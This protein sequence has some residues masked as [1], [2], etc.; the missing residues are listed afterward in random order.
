M[1]DSMPGN[2]EISVDRDVKV[3]M[4]DGVILRAD[5]YRPQSDRPVPVL[6][7]RTPYGKGGAQSPAYL[8]PTWYARHGYLVVTQ[9]V[10]GR[11]VSGGDWYPFEHEA[12]DGYD[13]IEWAAGLDG[14]TGRVGMYGFSYPGACQL[15]AAAEQPPHL[16]CII[17]AMTASEYWEGWTY[18]GGALQQAFVQSWVVNELGS[19]TARRR[20]LTTLWQRLRDATRDIA[21][22]YDRLPLRDME[23]AHAE[24]LAPYYVDWIDHPTR[25]KY[26]DRWSP[27]LRHGRI[28]VPALHLGG[29]YDIFLEG[30]IR[31]FQGIRAKAPREVADTQRLV[32]G[33][34]YHM[35]WAAHVAGWHFGA[36]ASNRM[37]D[38]QLRWF[39]HWLKGD[40]NSIPEEPPVRRFVMGANRWEDEV[41]WP[42]PAARGIDL[43]LSS[44]GG[45]N[46]LNGEGR[47]QA[48]PDDEAAPDVFAY[49]PTSAVPSLG[50]RSCCS[51]AMTPMGPANQLP[52][53]ILNSVLVYT[54]PVLQA[55]VELA[56]P[57]TV[58]LHAS[59]TARDTDWT[60]KLVDVHSE[61]LAVNVA[62]GILRARYRLSAS[63]PEPIE[64][65]R[66]EEYVIDVGATSI[67]LRAGHRIRLEVSS[68]NFPAYDRN[69]NTGGPIGREDLA[70][71]RI[72]T[73][74]VYHDRE[75]PSRIALSVIGDLRFHE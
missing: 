25:D 39:D 46:S 73:Q 70:A 64:P 54:S 24:E 44:G 45:A 71:A 52:V 50:G 43:H 14:S 23:L 40:P 10:R 11:G 72:A 20:G 28:A 35:Y 3:P 48:E 47:L 9:D 13:S 4:R 29:W 6:L 68:S 18:R 67:M 16:G 60:A 26:W 5:V 62:D 65:G 17:P 15:L 61:E 8:H 27:A 21:S 55:D 30:T 49:D 53:E 59:S 63:H 7:L 22:V 19:D 36:E 34:W 1:E 56:G 69:L 41:D 51:P 33:P 66:V 2:V 32:I 57:V 12:A 42:P 38:L 31:N 75:R 74:A 37:N 58:V